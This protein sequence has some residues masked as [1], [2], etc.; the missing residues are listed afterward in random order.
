[1][2]GAITATATA[3]RPSLIRAE[4]AIASRYVWTMLF[5]DAGATIDREAMS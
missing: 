5:Q 2:R 4:S 3:G 1:M